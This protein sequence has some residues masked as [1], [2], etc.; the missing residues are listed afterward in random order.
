[1]K[2]NYKVAF[3]AP[4]QPALIEW[5]MPEAGENEVLV[6]TELSLI[7]TGTELTVLERNVEEGTPWADSLMNYPIY[8]TGYSSSGRIVAVGK[9][10]S[11]D[12]IGRR[13]FTS[14]RHQ[15]YYTI[16]LKDEESYVWIPENV[17]SRDATIATLGCVANA[18]VRES[19]IA[20]GDPCVVY[21][22]GIVGQMV[23]RLAK[24]A[25]S[26]K[27]FVADISDFRLNM[28][29]DDPC[30]I[31]INSAKESVPEVVKAN[32]RW[33]KGV[34]FVFEVTSVPSLAMEQLSCL[35][36]CGK[37]IVTSSP[38]GRSLIDLDYCSRNGLSIIGAHNWTSHPTRENNHC[39]W[40]RHNDTV[41]MIDLISKNLMPVDNLFTHEYNYKDAPAAYE[42]LMKDRSQ[43]MC[44]VINWE[45]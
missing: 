17:S 43:A 8:H 22:A 11:E 37:L 13:L 44:V 28:I 4:K 21:G 6:K 42:M 25:G 1:M 16:N 33:G 2:T 12:M 34:P 24:L 39:F 20:P 14:A 45:D 10:V 38:K 31:K 32:T 19:K 3:M 7:S 27:I 41:H 40:T 29:P 36:E 5:D 23:A 18:S 15:S 26:T 35:K 9:N 30:F